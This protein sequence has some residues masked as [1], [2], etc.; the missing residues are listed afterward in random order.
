MIEDT[1]ESSERPAHPSPFCGGQ[2]GDPKRSL[3]LG[4]V[5]R[6]R[7]PGQGTVPWAW[8]AWARRGCDSGARKDDRL[9][10][11]VVVSAI[12]QIAGGDRHTT[13]DRGGR[14]YGRA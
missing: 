9:V 3:G 10:R 11:S 4:R 6:L 1:W 13:A 7:F 2:G 14:R 12:R 8:G 5:F